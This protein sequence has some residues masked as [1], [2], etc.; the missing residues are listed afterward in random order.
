[1]DAVMLDAALVPLL[2]TMPE[3]SFTA[4]AASRRCAKDR[5]SWGPSSCRT[6]SSASI[7]S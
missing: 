4:E 6:T 2:D 5:A 3:F 1:M 7:M